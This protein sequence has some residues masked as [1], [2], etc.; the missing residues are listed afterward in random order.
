MMTLVSKIQAQSLV[1]LVFTTV[2]KMYTIVI[3]FLL[4]LVFRECK[5]ESFQLSLF[6]FLYTGVIRQNPKFD[7]QLER[8]SSTKRRQ[9]PTSYKIRKTER[10]KIDFGY[11]KL[12]VQFSCSRG[13]GVI[14]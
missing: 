13:N 12:F 3:L 8:F 4:K 7:Q 14:S 11:G 10:K 1:S 5:T 6:V 9:H 2:K